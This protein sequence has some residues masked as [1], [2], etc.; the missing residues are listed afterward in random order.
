MLDQI[1]K[2]LGVP[3]LVN[4]T[5]LNLIV[6]QA[7]SEVSMCPYWLSMDCRSRLCCGQITK[8][9]WQFKEH[10]R[11]KLSKRFPEKTILVLEEYTIQ[12][13]STEVG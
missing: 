9:G 10:I 1:S 8:Q 3:G 7:L 6:A 12:S 2:E 11:T 13:N 5:L 4:R